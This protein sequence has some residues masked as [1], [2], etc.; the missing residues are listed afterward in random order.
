MIATAKQ[1]GLQADSNKLYAAYMILGSFTV[2]AVIHFF[3]ELKHA[4]ACIIF[5]KQHSFHLK[6]V[7]IRFD[8]V[9]AFL[10][11]TYDLTSYL[12]KVLYLR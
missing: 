9:C 2:I 12:A 3:A 1:L 10:S 6:I 11:C 8:T 4:V 7:H 5:G